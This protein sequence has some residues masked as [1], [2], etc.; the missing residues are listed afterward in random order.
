[1][2]VLSILMDVHTTAIISLDHF[3]VLVIRD[4]YLVQS[5]TRPAMVNSGLL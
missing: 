3:I 2:N 4:I 5:I 1:M